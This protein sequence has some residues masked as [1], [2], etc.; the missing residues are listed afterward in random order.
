MA[1]FPAIPG[2]G[3]LT[4]DPGMIPALPGGAEALVYTT[5]NAALNINL[6][7]RT[8]RDLIDGRMTPI[9]V[10]RDYV[11]GFHVVV[12]SRRQQTILRNL[13]QNR[14]SDNVC[15]QIVSDS[16]DRLNFERYESKDTSIKKFA[17]DFYITNDILGRQNEIYYEMIVDGNTTLGLSWNEDTKEVELFREPWWDGREGMFV[18]YDGKDKPV[19][20]VK[21]WFETTTLKYRTVYFPDRIERYS[22]DIGGGTPESWL[23]Y[24]LLEDTG[25]PIPWV[26]KNGKPLGI[27]V[28]HFPNA[29]RGNGNHGW[30]D[31]Q[32]VP[33]YQDQLNDLQ[34]AMSSAGRQTAY[35]MYAVSGY[36]RRNQNANAAQTSQ[37][38]QDESQDGSLEAAPG[39]VW[40]STSPDTKWQVLPAGNASSLIELYD[41]KVERVAEM[42]LTP[43]H[44]ITGEWPSGDAIVAAQ[45]PAVGKASK[46]VRKLQFCW[47]EVVYMA[48]K[49]SNLY[50]STSFPENGQVDV[51][52]APVE[53]TDPL[54]RASFV[55]KVAPQISIR[56]SLKLLGY[57]ETRSEE[58]YQE[59]LEEAKD[60]EAIALTAMN[61]TA[62]GGS[63]IVPAGVDPSAGTSKSQ[64]PN[65]ATQ[66]DVR[67]A[68]PG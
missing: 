44:V 68:V 25:Y 4:P 53:A 66:T 55:N 12:L 10:F 57:S 47:R 20:A 13:L 24:P 22:S 59:I 54:S 46:K 49:L 18:A 65:P 51:Q 23:P 21:E 60:K 30:S 29:G 45:Q 34:F 42:T 35:Q 14:F 48:M 9:R 38:K 67:I 28:I 33:A 3:N 19:Y 15:H 11:K 64:T 17:D 58:I 62:G 5:D 56:E 37:R 26:D 43:H 61:G 63:G 40:T 52:F 8:D 32:G 27:P 2:K 1:N 50:G 6:R 16:A 41:K 36:R 39:Q 7:I 31:L